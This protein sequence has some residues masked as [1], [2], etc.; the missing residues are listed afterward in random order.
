[1]K[2][3][4]V[5]LDEWIRDMGLDCMKVVD[6]H[7]ESQNDVAAKDAPVVKMLGP[8]SIVEAG[9]LLELNVPLA[10][11]AKIGKNWAETH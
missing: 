1:M 2:W 8:A 10:G 4:M 3:S 6:M 11:E 7:D 5:I 9:K